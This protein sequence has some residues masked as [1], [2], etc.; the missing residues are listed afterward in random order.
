MILFINVL[1][2]NTRLAHHARVRG[3]LNNPPRIDVYKYMLASLAAIPYWSK[4][5]IHCKLDSEF[6]GQSDA[7]E[8]YT[9]T[10]FGPKI[11]YH[12]TR[13]EYQREW[14]DGLQE[15][16]DHDDKLV[17]FLCND[18]HIFMDYDLTSI[19]E[20]MTLLEPQHDKMAS[21]FFSHHPEALKAVAHQGNRKGAVNLAVYDG[22]N[23]DS[24][25]LVTKKV[26][27]RWFFENEDTTRFMPRPDWSTGNVKTDLTRH[28]VPWK[29]CCRHFEGYPMVNININHCPPLDIPDGFFEGKVKVAYGDYAGPE[30]T[31]FNPLVTN[32]KT[33]DPNGVD[34]KMVPADMPFFWES[35]ISAISASG[36]DEEA[37]VRARNE[38]VWLAANSRPNQP[39]YVINQSMVMAVAGRK[40]HAET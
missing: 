36:I 20:A 9:K 24:I 15:V 33:V 3:W 30:W 26:L 8:S 35:Y 10:L 40:L 2:T 5:I 11:S 29:E 6:E 32:Y 18:D 14:R 16:F 13:L 23:V 25:Q 28:Y 34:Y 37:S 22:G 39:D 17:W 31:W 38:A 1:V 7:L 27:R 21:F 19:E 4:V 12:H